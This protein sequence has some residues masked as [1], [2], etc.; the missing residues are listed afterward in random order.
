MIDSHCH[1]QHLKDNKRKEIIKELEIK[2]LKVII[3][4]TNLKDSLKVLEISQSSS[5]IFVSLGIHPTELDDFKD[6]EKFKNLVIENQNKIVAIGECG[7]DFYKLKDQSLKNL[8]KELFLKQIE[9]SL[10]INKPLVIHSRESFNEVFD[11]LKNSHQNKLVMHFFTGSKAEAK[12]FLDLGAYLSFST[13]ITLTSDY[14][15]VV[16]YVPLDRIFLETDSPFIRSNT[17]IDV[18]K[19]YQKAA[20]LK[21]INYNEFVSKIDSNVERFFKINS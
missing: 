15:E 3:I 11:I 2:N 8:Q 19:V 20:A 12:R 6:F 14:D 13:V 16:K 21:N 5:L 10:E 18:E 1:L 7:L 4:G 9:L 17:P